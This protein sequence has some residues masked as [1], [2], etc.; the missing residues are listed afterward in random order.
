MTAPL[1]PAPPIDTR[2]HAPDATLPDGTPDRLPSGSPEP[3]H[4]LAALGKHPLHPMLIHIPVAA[5]LG[6]VATDLAWLYTRDPFWMR[7]GI[8]LA[9]VG[10][11]GGWLASAV[12]LIDLLAVRRIREKISAWA[13]AL[14]AVMLL[15]LA[16]CNWLL[17]FAGE[18]ARQPET[19]LALSL[20]S[21][22]ATG[23]AAWLGGR[24]VYEHAVGVAH[25]IAPAEDH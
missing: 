10:A 22:A 23:L 18:H 15:S 16:T 17:R 11:G 20:G 25:R 12:G 21:A 7:A 14:A 13:H 4:S 3:I 19:A 1:P 6:L 8:W 5:L 2:H 9:G 24:L